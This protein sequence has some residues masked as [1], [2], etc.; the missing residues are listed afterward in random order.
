MTESSISTCLIQICLMAICLQ[1]TCDCHGTP[2]VSAKTSWK[3]SQLV[4]ESHIHSELRLASGRQKSI[5]SC[6][7]RIR[8]FCSTEMSNLYVLNLKYRI[9][10]R[11][12]LVLVRYLNLH[13]CYFVLSNLPF[14]D[15]RSMQKSSSH[16]LRNFN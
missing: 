15:G 9:K 6:L 5:M 12:F 13:S 2:R 3:R 14:I 4:I 11:L 16:L 10:S 7:L 8:I 1:F